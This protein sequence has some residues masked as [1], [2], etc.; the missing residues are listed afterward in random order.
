MGSFIQDEKSVSKLVEIIDLSE[1]K[2]SETSDL[3]IRLLRRYM[4][5]LAK[6][7]REKLSSGE[8]ALLGMDAEDYERIVHSK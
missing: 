1:E 8:K 6:H 7:P 2:D 4:S 5:R 3:E